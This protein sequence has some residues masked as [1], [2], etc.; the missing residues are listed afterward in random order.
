[1]LCPDIFI[2]L[3]LWKIFLVDI[4][5]RPNVFF[6][7]PKTEAVTVPTECGPPVAHIANPIK[8]EHFIL[9]LVSY[10]DFKWV[11]SADMF[12]LTLSVPALKSHF[13]AHLP[14]K[15]PPYLFVNVPLKCEMSMR[16]IVL[17]HSSNWQVPKFIPYILLYQN[18]FLEIGVM[19]GICHGGFPM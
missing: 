9:G 11:A 5:C 19:Q 8:H 7:I 4:F 17:C 12:D 18:I 15:K 14:L 13:P 3:S 2:A 16:R 6:S 10:E 1:M